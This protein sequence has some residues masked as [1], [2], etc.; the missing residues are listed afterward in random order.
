MKVANNRHPGWVLDMM[1]L[2][3]GRRKE[4]LNVFELIQRG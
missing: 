3:S 1:A 2:A 4:Y